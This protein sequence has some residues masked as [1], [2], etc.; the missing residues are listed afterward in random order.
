[1]A[2]SPKTDQTREMKGKGRE[3]G[4]EVRGKAQGDFYKTNRAIKV[5]REWHDEPLKV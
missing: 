1:M 5:C 3:R 4:G 2:L